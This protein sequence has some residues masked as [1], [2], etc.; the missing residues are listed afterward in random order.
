MPFQYSFSRADYNVGYIEGIGPEGDGWP[1]V[2]MVA[3]EGKEN[4]CGNVEVT[5][6]LNSRE[7]ATCPNFGFGAEAFAH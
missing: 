3:N 4:P 2:E 7:P 1:C 5:G 6:Y